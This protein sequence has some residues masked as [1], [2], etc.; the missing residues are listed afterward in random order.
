MSLERVQMRTA[1][2]IPQPKSIVPGSRHD[3]R[4]IWGECDRTNSLCMSLERVQMRTADCI[5]QL[6][7]FVR[8]SRHDMDA[9]QGECDRMNRR[10]MSLHCSYAQI[11]CIIRGIKH[12]H[13]CVQLLSIHLHN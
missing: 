5:P 9:I 2:C 8:G 4:A 10:G 12:L 13:W 11:P 3:T 7:T 1:D 6:K